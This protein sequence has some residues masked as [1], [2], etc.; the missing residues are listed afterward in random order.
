METLV[1]DYER[2][3]N[4]HVD[5]KFNHPDDE[6]TIEAQLEDLRKLK[7]EIQNYQGNKM[8]IFMCG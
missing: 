1:N 5:F 3:I 2:K 6:A 8:F 4:E 7:T